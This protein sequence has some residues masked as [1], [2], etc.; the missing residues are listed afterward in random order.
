MVSKTTHII[1]GTLHWA[2]V[3][4]KPRLNTY[5]NE[6]E[7]SVDVTPDAKGMLELKRL[8][9]TN[10][11]KNKNDDRKEFLSFRQKEF[12]TMKDGSKEANRPIRI[13]DIK[14]Q[15][16]PEGKLIG[17]GS[18]AD[19]KFVLAPPMPGKPNAGLYIQAIRVLDL[20]S[21]ETQEFAPLSEDDEFFAET[22]GEPE[23]QETTADYDYDD[24]VPF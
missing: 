12:R 3:L 22:E 6:N 10:K 11:L 14:G 17:N 21:Y 19:V 13:L 23:A 7:W 1:R 15:P 8:K 9:L 2:K 16:W 20:V 18:T 5:S 4:G 24:D